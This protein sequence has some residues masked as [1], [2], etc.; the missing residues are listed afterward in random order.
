[1]KPPAWH[2]TRVET[3]QA[4][5]LAPRQSGAITARLAA[6]WPHAIVWLG[7]VL[8]IAWSGS[9]AWFLLRLLDVI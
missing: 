9:L 1:M 8:T 2:L 5:E 6:L 4:V 3:L 7:I